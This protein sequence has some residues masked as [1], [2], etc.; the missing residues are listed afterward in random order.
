MKTLIIIILATI[1][2][3]CG[4]GQLDT[5]IKADSAIAQPEPVTQPSVPEV[6]QCNLYSYNPCGS[7]PVP[8]APT[9]CTPGTVGCDAP[10]GMEL[11][12][13]WSYNPC[14]HPTWIAKQPK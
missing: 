8:P 7:A 9:T 1:L 5:S 4:G 13:L 2:T 10:E 6:P 11:C 14:A 12:D 3:A